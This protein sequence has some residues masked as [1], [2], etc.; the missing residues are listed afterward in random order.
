MVKIPNQIRAAKKFN[1]LFK[2]ILLLFW[3]C[4][5]S[6]EVYA[7]SPYIAQGKVVDTTSALTLKN[8]V[9]TVLRAKDS[10]YV[11]FTRA[12]DDGGFVFN[13]LDTGNY[14]LIASYPKYTD[15]VER[16]TVDPDHPK[17]DFG[18][19]NLLLLS[20]LLNEVVITGKNAIT[21]KGDTIEFD[22]SK[23]TIQANSRVEDLLAQLPGI[24]VDMNGKI[25]AQGEVVSKVLVDGEEFFGDDPT[26]VTRNIRGDMVDKVQLY[27]K[28]SDQATFTGI[29]DGVKNKTINIIGL[30][31][32]AVVS[33]AVVAETVFAWPGIGRLLVDAVRFRDYPVIQG[34][35]LLAV[36][37]VVI[38]NLLADLMITLVNPRV[39]M[40]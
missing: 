20:Q 35:T 17:V 14:I 39:R 37:C 33:G 1:I 29:D 10:I 19:I 4:M 16:F 38:V 6:N 9:V 7:Q 11:D 22:A 31:F 25:T 24:Q 15:F 3:G 12:G 21:I 34:V 26:L 32:G 28:K 36:A 27:D 30:N 40:D 13:N 5:L 2:S 18:S 8:T 23:Y